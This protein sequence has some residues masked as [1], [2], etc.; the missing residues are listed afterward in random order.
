MSITSIAIAVKEGCREVGGKGFAGTLIC[1][2]H[3][4]DYS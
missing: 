2:C 3:I 1:G 4:A